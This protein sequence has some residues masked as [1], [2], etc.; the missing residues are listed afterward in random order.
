MTNEQW[1]AIKDRLWSRYE[2]VGYQCERFIYQGDFDT[3][4]DAARQDLTRFARPTIEP[5]PVSERV[6]VPEDCAPWPDD[7]NIS[8]CWY[9]REHEEGGWRWRQDSLCNPR[10]YGYT[11]WLPHH[12]LPVPGAEVE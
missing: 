4:L 11:H 6:P 8:W 3:A 7:P 1:D 12:A 5:V 2:T 9:A 10:A